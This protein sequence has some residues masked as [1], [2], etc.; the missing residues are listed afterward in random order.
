MAQIK[1]REKDFDDEVLILE[2]KEQ[3]QHRTKVDLRLEQIRAITL[4]SVLESF[5]GKVAE[6]PQG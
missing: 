4:N 5:Q 2:R 6:N 1:L 3:R